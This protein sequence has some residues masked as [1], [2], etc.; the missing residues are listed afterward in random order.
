VFVGLA[1]SMDQKSRLVHS[2]RPFYAKKGCCMATL[3]LSKISTAIVSSAV[4]IIGSAIGTYGAYLSSQSAGSRIDKSLSRHDIAEEEKLQI[5]DFEIQTSTEGKPVKR[6]YGRVKIVG[7]VIWATNY[8]KNND[9][10]TLGPNKDE[11][12]Y[13]VNFAVGLCEGPI[14]H[15]GRIWANGTLL[16]QSTLKIR[17]YRGTDNQPVDSL[18]E[19]KQSDGAPAYRGLAYAVFEGFPLHE[20]GN[21]IPQL[22]FEVVRVVESIE[23]QIRAVAITPGATEYSYGVTPVRIKESPT[24]EIVENIHNTLGIT[25]FMASLDEL[26][27]MC[28]NLKRISLVVPWFG[29]DLRA[30]HCKLQPKMAA[31]IENRNMSNWWVGGAVHSYNENE[32][33]VSLHQGRGAYGGTPSDDTVIEAINEIHRRGLK[34]TLHPTIL[35]DIPEDNE[36]PNPFGTGVGQ[37]AYPWCGHITCYPAP[38]QPGSPAN[39]KSVIDQVHAFV[40][41]IPHDNFFIGDSAPRSMGFARMILHYAELASLACADGCGIDSF[42]LSSSLPGL[43]LLRSSADGWY[44]PFVELLLRLAPIV[45]RI[46][47]GIKVSYGA[48]WSEWYG[49]PTK[50]AA[51]RECFYFHLDSFW[52]SPH[53]SFVGIT[54]H[55]PLSDWRYGNHLDA[56]KANSVYD[57]DYLKGNISSGEYY[58]WYY[59]SQDDR[60]NQIRSPISDDRHGRPWMFRAKDFSNWW[61]NRHIERP[62]PR[63]KRRPSPW[64]P[65]SKPIVFTSI[66]CPA[67][68]L[69]AN[70]PYVLRHQKSTGTSSP[71]FSRG[72]RDDFMMRRFIEAH[73]ATWSKESSI[74]PISSVYDGKM[75]DPEGVVWWSWDARPFPHFPA[76]SD[77]WSDTKSWFTGPFLNGRLGGP[78][79][80]TLLR[81]I[82]NDYGFDH[83]KVEFSAISGQIEGYVIDNRISARAALEPLLTCFLVDAHDIGTGIRFSGRNRKSVASLSRDDMIETEDK[84]LFEMRRTQENELPSSISVNVYDLLRDF[85]RTTVTSSRSSIENTRIATA[86]LPIVAPI[87]WMFGLVES[88]LQDVWSSRETICFN[89]SRNWL[90]LEPGDII[91]IDLEYPQGTATHHNFS[92]RS[93]IIEKIEDNLGRRIEARVIDPEV[94]TPKKAEGRQR[95]SA[96]PNLIGKP[97]VIVIDAPRSVE[98]S[99]AHK[100]LIAA[101]AIPWPGALSIWRCMP[102]EHWKPIGSVP[103]SATC[104]ETVLPFPDGVVNL[105]DD[106]SVLRVKL[107]SGSLSSYSEED[108][109][110]G[111]NMAAVQD[112]SGDW[113]VFQFQNAVLVEENTW[114]LSRFLRGKYVSGPAIRGNN[115]ERIKLPSDGSEFLVH[116]GSFF[117]LP[118]KR[119]FVLL[120]DTLVAL[121]ISMRDIGSPV[122]LKIG[123]SCYDY[124]H[125]SY[126][127]VQFVPSAVALRPCPP[128]HIRMQHDSHSREGIELTWVRQSRAP[129]ADSWVLRDIPMHE[130]EEKY[131]VETGLISKSSFSSRSRWVVHRRISQHANRLFDKY[132]LGISNYGTGLSKRFQVSIA[133]VGTVSGSSQKFVHT[134]NLHGLTGAR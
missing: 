58:D 49:H 111:A 55:I 34:V 18:I 80:E 89:L 102:G 92:R 88:W 132:M 115:S 3:L 71:Y 87:D 66:G 99:E 12:T 82:L 79:I 14:N 121:D 72:A 106:I 110:N 45:R 93:A 76:L 91:D 30:S 101:S 47:P 104:G 78:S 48:D 16:E 10:T 19:A 31:E 109:L 65:E 27:E 77:V 84:P 42:L 81:A 44:Y 103:R 131:E 7:Q 75:V 64:V 98:T 62:G 29:N 124:R 123:P 54:N 9:N 39:T 94:L 8:E 28:P 60:D 90:R 95:H 129:G 43:T 5:P 113:E 120:D 112:T 50:D 86:N 17:C 13:S 4:S 11:A 85:H 6:V 68:D 23:S 22:A 96:I 52:A 51:G 116:T 21:R 127:A 105:W 59:A 36:L 67:L 24:R 35:M 46:S 83:I 69:G 61:S 100:P 126:V 130:S 25:D 1:V 2:L 134:L 122:S 114:E 128:A 41:E 74:N 70:Q 107:Y 26:Q 20:Y 108:V 40:G 15:V 117:T 73:M 33:R 57:I 63:A 53:V 119:P 37:P 32:E 38:G 133:Q 97:H 56:N 118:S 125:S